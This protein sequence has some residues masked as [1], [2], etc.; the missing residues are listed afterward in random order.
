VPVA[1]SC[2]GDRVEVAAK[3][4]FLLRPELRAPGVR[5]GARP[6]GMCCPGRAGVRLVPA[7]PGDPRPGE[8]ESLTWVPGVKEQN[9]V[10]EVAAGALVARGGLQR[11][12]VA[13]DA[14]AGGGAER[15]GEGPPVLLLDHGAPARLLREVGHGEVGPG[16]RRLDGA[17]PCQEG[18]HQLSR[19]WGALGA[20]CCRGCAKGTCPGCSH[21]LRPALAAATSA[22]AT[23]GCSLGARGSA[24]V[25]SSGR[26]AAVWEGGNRPMGAPGPGEQTGCSPRGR[27]SSP[28]LHPLLPPLRVEPPSPRG[29]ASPQSPAASPQHRGALS[30]VPSTGVLSAGSPLRVCSLRRCCQHPQ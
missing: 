29:T 25:G 14:G 16:S 15:D 22:P 20:P 4:G 21:T 1:P 30:G 23:Q 26:S 28:R 2:C 3:W 13:A 8:G 10:P 7:S 19:C 17:G 27:A 9:E 11:Q 5:N 6:V 24:A 18:A 12:A